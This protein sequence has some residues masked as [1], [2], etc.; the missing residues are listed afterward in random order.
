M[1]SI[2]FC[3][4]SGITEEWSNQ[5]VN[6]RWWI[7]CK[8][9]RNPAWTGLTSFKAYPSIA[10]NPG[11]LWFYL[12]LLCGW[13]RKLT[14]SSQARWCKTHTNHDLVTCVFLRLSWFASF[15]FDFSLA[16]QGIFLSYDLL[17]WILW[18]WFFSIQL[19]S[20]LKSQVTVKKFEGHRFD[21]YGKWDV[22]LCSIFVKRQW[23]YE[24]DYFFHTTL[25]WRNLKTCPMFQTFKSDIV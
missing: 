13:S 12:T 14:P 5:S 16:V 2:T 15:H 9:S 23:H 3:I 1:T 22:I 8:R 21:S 19:K 10:K 6:G 4:L 11:F 24:K 17:L 25:A 7:H 18:S 20:T